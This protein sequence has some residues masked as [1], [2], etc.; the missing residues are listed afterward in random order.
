MNWSRRSFLL[1]SSP[2]SWAHQPYRQPSERA[3]ALLHVV[4]PASC[5][6]EQRIIRIRDGAQVRPLPRPLT[7]C[8]CM[9]TQTL[10]ALVTIV[11][12]CATSALAHLPWPIPFTT[13]LRLTKTADSHS[14]TDLSHSQSRMTRRASARK[15]SK[16][17]CLEA[18]SMILSTTARSTFR[19]E[20]PESENRRNRRSVSRQDY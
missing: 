3:W 20:T 2:S 4:L 14:L 18:V 17:F 8:V 12:R 15:C 9:L 5:A 10:C 11:C 16:Y 13:A 7:H 19:I 6:C 1:L